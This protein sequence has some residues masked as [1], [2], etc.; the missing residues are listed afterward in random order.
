MK[1]LLALLELIADMPAIQGPIADAL[2]GELK[3]HADPG[4]QKAVKDFFTTLAGKL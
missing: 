2:T 4:V 1:S 3:R